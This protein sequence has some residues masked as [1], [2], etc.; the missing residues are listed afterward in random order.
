MKVLKHRPYEERLRELGL[1]RLEK[2]RLMRPTS[3][4]KSLK[5]G[6]S[7]VRVSLF[8]CAASN[9]TRGNGLKLCRGRFRLEVRKKK[10]EK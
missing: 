5:G 10:I 2:R 7:E 8:S 4:L 9:R 6:C 3:S 1:F